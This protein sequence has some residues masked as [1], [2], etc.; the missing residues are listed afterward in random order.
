MAFGHIFLKLF[1]LASQKWLPKSRIGWEHVPTV[2]IFLEPWSAMSPVST[3]SALRSVF[4]VRVDWNIRMVKG[5]MTVKTFRSHICIGIVKVSEEERIFFK[6][7][8]EF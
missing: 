3:V 4:I 6:V 8:C 2:P 7:C 1:Q 5:V